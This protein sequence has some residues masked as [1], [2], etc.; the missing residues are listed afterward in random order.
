MM[1]LWNI[2]K[3]G[4]LNPCIYD[5]NNI[6][7]A[8]SA[9]LTPPHSPT[10][11]FLNQLSSLSSSGWTFSFLAA[12]TLLWFHFGM[13][14]SIKLFVIIFVLQT[15]NYVTRFE[16]TPVRMAGRNQKSGWGVHMAQYLCLYCNNPSSQFIFLK[17]G[18]CDDP[19]LHAQTTTNI[20]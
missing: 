4:F 16:S 20:F 2:Q 1:L 15:N 9:F 10:L 18:I 12:W 14:I 5:S 7:N 6:Q 8:S 17:S 13:K 3:H 19:C 11:S